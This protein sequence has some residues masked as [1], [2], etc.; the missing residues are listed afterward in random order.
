M[1][2]FKTKHQIEQE[3]RWLQ[4][5]NEYN[6]LVADKKKSKVAINDYL[7]RKYGIV[8]ASTIYTIRKRVEERILRK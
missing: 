2:V 5:Y 3:K 1:E 6:A 7:C 8:A 4:I